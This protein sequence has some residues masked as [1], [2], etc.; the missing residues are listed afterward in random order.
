MTQEEEDK[1]HLEMKQIY[2]D[3]A[4]HEYEIVEHNKKII[5]GFGKN[6]KSDFIDLL[7]SVDVTEKIEFVEKPKGDKQNESYGIFKNVYVEQWSTGMEGD[8][9][10]G[11]IYSFVKNKWIKIPYS[12]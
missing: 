5:E 2:A 3:L 9:Y 6:A 10:S 4:E 1:M 12:C 8:S 7:D 11:F